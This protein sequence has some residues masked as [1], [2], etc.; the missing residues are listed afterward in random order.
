MLEKIFSAQK[1]TATASSLAF[2]I[3]RCI[4]TFH[5]FHVYGDGGGGGGGVGAMDVNTY[6]NDIAFIIFSTVQYY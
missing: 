5:H 1:T 2:V 6:Y 3:V 4:Y